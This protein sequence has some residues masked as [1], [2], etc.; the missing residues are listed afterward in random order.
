MICIALAGQSPSYEMFQ[1]VDS[2]PAETPRANTKMWTGSTWGT[3]T[4]VGAIAMCNRIG[5]AL[6]A[7]G[8][9]DEVRIYNVAVGG[10]SLIA[11]HAQPSTNHWSAGGAPL[12]AMYDQIDA[13]CTIPDLIV[14]WQGWQ[15]YLWYNA[16]MRGVYEG[17]LGT[18]FSGWK[19]TLGKSNL[20]MNVWPSGRCNY[21]GNAPAM[22]PY[23]QSAQISFATSTA[24]VSLGPSNHHQPLRDGVHQSGDGYRSSGTMGATAVLAQLSIEGYA[25]IEMP[26]VISAARSG[27]TF[28]LT[29]N[30]EG[31][32][33]PPD[34]WGNLNLTG[35]QAW[36]DAWG[37]V[38]IVGAVAVGNQVRLDFAWTTGA[39]VVYQRGITP[40][41]ARICYTKIK[42]YY[43]PLAPISDEQLFHS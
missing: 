20:L 12:Q 16:N 3:V 30:V 40:D 41:I 22:A 10:S 32:L 14:W 5:A 2:Y 43:F 21:G 19:T 39:H 35:F 11:A 4:G 8:L 18:L 38:P 24:G 6:A 13:G 7:A 36:D 27:S 17:A 31:A 42:G 25:G 28:V 34:I 37:D 29:T 23:V 33:V 9:D 1:N 15:D 26:R